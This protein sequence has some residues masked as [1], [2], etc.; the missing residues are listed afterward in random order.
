MQ[1]DRFGRVLAAEGVS[2]FGSMLSRLAIPWLA[3]L[4]LQASA[5]QMALLLVADVAAAAAGA[6]LL[7]GWVDRSGKRAVMLLADGAR[8]GLLLLLALAA[9][10]GWAT[11]AL[12]VAAAAAIGLSGVAFELARSAW[13][14]QCVAAPR[15]PQR[16]A[17]LSAVGSVS[18]TAAFALG[19]WLYQGLGAALALVVDACSY[20]ASALC[21]RGVPEVPPAPR[22]AA[23]ASSPWRAWLTEAGAGLRAVAERPAL[24]ALAAVEVLLATSLA[25]TGTSI[26]IHTSRDLALPTGVLGLVF[27][28]GGL[29]SLV[30]A[31]LA[32]GLG[33]RLGAGGAMTLGLAGYAIG[34]AC[35]ASA[36]GAGWAAVACLAAQQIVGDAGHTLHEVH[37]RGLRQTAV[38][39][40]LLARTDAGIRTV[41]Y[42]ATGAGAVIG[43]WVG[44]AADAR[45]VLWLAVAAATGAA[46]VAAA[47][48]A[49]RV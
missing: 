20:A 3:T 47:K 21:L 7:G 6:L 29:G 4:A 28:L 5:A 16:N 27:A 19:G 35:L 34:T 23:P 44:T 26:M 1:D 17:Q 9:W 12:L 37:D 42:L 25:L 48:L 11:M 33:R 45:T 39:A 46:G 24:R 41:G 18:E 38:P 8:S 49:R 10:Q 15:L 14:A 40:A 31:A 2:N 22:A 43:G 36:T 13:V 30:A 32:P